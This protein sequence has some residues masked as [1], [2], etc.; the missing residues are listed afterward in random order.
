MA[1]QSVRFPIKKRSEAILAQI[2]GELKE[3]ILYSLLR[4]AIEKGHPVSMSS[5]KWLEPLKYAGC[6]F[7]LGLLSVSPCFRKSIMRFKISTLIILVIL[8]TWGCKKPTEYRAKGIPSIYDLISHGNQYSG[9][10]VVI[11]GYA[12]REEHGI[13]FYT[14]K[15]FA[16]MRAYSS[17]IFASDSSEFWLPML[18]SE[19]KD[20]Y[21]RIIGKFEYIEEYQEFGLTKVD[22]ILIWDFESTPTNASSI[23]STK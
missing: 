17:G 10:T 22:S 15:E 13:R 20:S 4:K 8:S 5:L 11:Y 1:S 12:Q 6:P 3:S 19:W 14:S 21:G 23:W 16:K 18:N 9:K 7:F 2:E